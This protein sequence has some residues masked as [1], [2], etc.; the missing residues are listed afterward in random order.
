MNYNEIEKLLT[1]AA[2]EL[3]IT[4]GAKQEQI[5]NELVA[6]HN[7]HC[8]ATANNEDIIYPNEDIYLAELLPQD[9]LEAFAIGRHADYCYTDN[10]L[11]LDGYGRPITTTHTGLTNFISTLDIADWLAGKGEDEQKELLKAFLK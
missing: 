4:S 1:K 3:E 2:Q 7:S 6:L 11:T 5:A 9:P 8:T 10:W